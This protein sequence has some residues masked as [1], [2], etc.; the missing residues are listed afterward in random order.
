MQSADAIQ[1][2]I[3]CGKITGKVFPVEEIAETDTRSEINTENGLES[4]SRLSSR[5]VGFSQSWNGGNRET[6]RID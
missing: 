2:D 6:P 3:L 5:K 1:D 4:I